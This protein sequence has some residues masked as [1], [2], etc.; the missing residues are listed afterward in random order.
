MIDTIILSIPKSAI[1]FLNDSKWDLSARTIGYERYIRNPW[2][3]EKDSGLYFPRLSG[4]K[5]RWK[6][7][8]DFVRI[9]FSVPK[10]VFLNNLT[11]L[12]DTDFESLIKTLQERLKMMNI[13]I[14]KE[15]LRRASVR[16]VHF[17]KNIILRDGYTTSYIIKELNKV[18]MR[19]NIDMTKARYINGGESLCAHTTTHEMI[20]YDKV[21]DLKKWTKRAIDKS[22]TVYQMNLFE[23]IQ[24]AKT[25]I[26][27]IEIR[28]SDTNKMNRILE[29]LWYNKNPHFFEVFNTEMSQ[30]ALL[31][32]WK[33]YIIDWALGTHSTLTTPHE[34]LTACL[35]KK[36]KLKEA[37]YLTGLVLLSR[38]GDGVRDLRTII[39]KN[40]HERTW[41]RTVSDLKKME[42]ILADIQYPRSWVTQLEKALKEYAPIKK[43]VVQEFFSKITWCKQK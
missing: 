13:G 42:T 26:L 27:R 40:A 16:C 29:K 30:K 2:R 22:Q 19:K 10:I 39:T 11:E 31:Y 34:I 6:E 9:E 37:I 21:S 5:T 24:K 12:R 23:P 35:S 7:D 25:E 4:Y 36:C 32:Y 28:L 20:I 3:R 17:S 8:A 15:T 43:E 38:D 18:N 33:T 41:Y 1:T 14:E